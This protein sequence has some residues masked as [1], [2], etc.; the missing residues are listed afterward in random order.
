MMHRIQNRGYSCPSVQRS[1]AARNTGIPGTHTGSGD[2][3]PAEKQRMERELMSLYFVMTE[4]E[5]YLDG[6]PDSRDALAR[7]KCTV[8]EYKEL[9]DRFEKEFGPILA[10]NNSANEWLWA[11]D[12]WPWEV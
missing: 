8:R 4:L 10:R 9:A 2:R 11:K 3:N 6:H 1:A 12:P 5:L 7:Y